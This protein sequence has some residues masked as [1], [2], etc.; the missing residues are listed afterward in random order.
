MNIDIV[1]LPDFINKAR[2]C[3]KTSNIETPLTKNKP[4]LFKLSK[5]KILQFL[6]ILTE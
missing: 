5:A 1:I 2:Q 4:C 6:V 3:S